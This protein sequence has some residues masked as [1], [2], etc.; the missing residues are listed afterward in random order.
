M[1]RWSAYSLSTTAS[2]S[3]CPRAVVLRSAT[4]SAP[5]ASRTQMSSEPR[6]TTSSS[7]N[8]N[9]SSCATCPRRASAPRARI[10]PRPR[11]ARP[12]RR[13]PPTQIGARALD[14]HG[15]RA[16]HGVAEQRTVQRAGRGTRGPQPDHALRVV[17]EA[18][19]IVQGERAV[20]ERARN[21]QRGAGSGTSGSGGAGPATRGAGTAATSNR[22][23]WPSGAA[24]APPPAAAAATARPR[25]AGGMDVHAH[26]SACDRDVRDAGLE[27]GSDDAELSEH[28]LQLAAPRRPASRPAAA[29]R[30]PVSRRR[31]PRGRP[32][33]PRP[34]CRRP[35]AARTPGPSSDLPRASRRRSPTSP[36]GPTATAA[37][38]PGRRSA[39]GRGRTRPGTRG[40]WRH[41]S[42]SARRRPLPRP[43]VRPPR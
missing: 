14:A 9:G 11:R 28:A 12:P 37:R 10:S 36:S 19:A 1:A 27:R 34:P 22:L 16:M 35:R 25:V 2:G 15:N 26:L 32:P 42:S 23:S 7:Q 4:S 17:R 8:A 29:G 39:T 41:G 20:G 18:A 13:D 31:R 40:P 3:R 6:S 24:R 30:A 43:A 5:S 33:P 38:L 21:M